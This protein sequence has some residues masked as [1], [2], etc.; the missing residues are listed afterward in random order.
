MKNTTLLLALALSA[1]SAFQAY[2]DDS[3]KQ[4]DEIKSSAG[5]RLEFV[6]TTP[7]VDSILNAQKEADR[8][9]VPTPRFVVK[10]QNNNFIMTIG[11]VINPFMGFDIGN[12]LYDQDDAGGGFTTQAIPV[13]AQ[14]GHK[15][16]FFINPVNGNIDLTVVGLG[17]TKN[18]I[19]GYIK[20][21]TNGLTPQVK[22]KRA[23]VSWRGI[24]AG[25][26]ATLMEDGD[27]AQPPT[28]DPQGPSGI[29]GNTAYEINY[30]S[31]YYKGFRF[32]VAIDK[33]TF[34]SSNGVYRG[35]D[36]PVF[37]D[38][39]VAGI[40][41]AE[42]IVP[43]IPA[44]VEYKHSDNNRIRLSGLLRDFAYRDLLDNKIRHSVGWGVM[45]SG[46]LQPVEPLIIYLQAA[47]GKGIGAYIQDLSGLPLSFYPKNDEPGR[48]TPAPMAGL[49]LGF[50]INA[51]KKLQFNL[52]ASEARIWN[53]G[54]YANALEMDQN[55]KYAVYTAAN[56]FYSITSYLQCGIEYLWGRRETWKH[57]G[58]NDNRIQT[59]LIFTL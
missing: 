15:G 53:V 25:M 16:D 56:C 39:Q 43:D 41:D 2:A 12:N 6:R 35:K 54:A 23:Y 48:M 33:P 42:Q 45:L 40:G 20:L 49:N 28:I 30:T 5:H 34:T 17:T 38:K 13:P 58:A 24:T 3:A 1:A 51:T 22:L 50:T 36:F 27:A 21:G 9:E 26:K 4:D 47:Y 14:T 7:Q 44:Y 52:M 8:Y 10:S 11:G 57:T 32:A 46:N 37:Y 29:V 55:Y 59:Q 31:P 18:A 19:T